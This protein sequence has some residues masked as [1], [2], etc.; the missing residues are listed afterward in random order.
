MSSAPQESIS[1]IWPP[2]AL[3]ATNFTVPTTIGSRVTV[4]FARGAL[5][6]ETG[7]DGQG[8]IAD[9]PRA[10]IVDP[11]TTETQTDTS[12]VGRPVEA[13]PTR[14]VGG[15]ARKAAALALSATL[16]AGG[17]ID[18]GIQAPLGG[19]GCPAAPT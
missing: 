13:R 15:L 7:I 2:D 5:T 19:L 10:T 17:P 9:S 1:S 12:Q 14:K 6:H 16:I 4:G 3:V 11:G 8:S 18:Y